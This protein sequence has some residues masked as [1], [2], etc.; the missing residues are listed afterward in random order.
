MYQLYSL[1]QHFSHVTDEAE[2]HI[3]TRT[4]KTKLFRLCDLLVTFRCLLLG[5]NKVIHNHQRCS[6]EDR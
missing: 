3:I 2:T 5:L 1:S 4:L 6:P